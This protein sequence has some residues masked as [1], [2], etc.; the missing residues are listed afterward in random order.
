M[1]F[2]TVI[3]NKPYGNTIACR[4]KVDYGL[5]ILWSRSLKID[6]RDQYTVESL[7]CTLDVYPERSWNLPTLRPIIFF[8]F[9]LPVFRIRDLLIPIRM[10]ILGSVPLTGSG[11]C[12]F[13]QWPSRSQ[14][15][16]FVFLQVFIRIPYWRYSYIFLQRWK[17]IERSQNRRNKSFFLH[18]LACWWKDPDPDK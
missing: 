9:I 3:I 8:L 6:Y 7:E 16:Q 18:F 5:W 13:R 2:K 15:K 17:V 14:Q 1:L 12:S 10:R 4:S 11:S